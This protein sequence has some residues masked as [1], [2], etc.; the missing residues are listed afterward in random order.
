[1]HLNTKNLQ[2]KHSHESSYIFQVTHSTKDGSFK[3]TCM[4]FEH[5]R[6]LCRHIFCVFKFYGIEKIPEKYILKRW[7][8]DVIPTELL[9]RRFNSSSTVDRC[10][11]FLSLDAAK[12]KLYLDKQNKLKKKIRRRLSNS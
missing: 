1:M 2:L 8:R 3:Y 7:R 11:S 9:K 10:V 5:V 12:L 4:H 6:I